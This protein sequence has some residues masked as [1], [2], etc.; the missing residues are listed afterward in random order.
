MIASLTY[1]ET[2]SIAEKLVVS[3]FVKKCYLQCK[4][5]VIEQKTAIVYESGQDFVSVYEDSQD[6]IAYFRDTTKTTFST[7]ET[8][9]CFPNEYTLSTTVRL[10]VF[11]STVREKQS[12]FV[13]ELLRSL[14]G[15]TILSIEVNQYNTLAEELGATEL[16]TDGFTMAVMID[17]L[18]KEIRKL[19][20]CGAAE[21]D[22]C[23]VVNSVVC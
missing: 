11:G 22:S 10:V 13:N 8:E 20:D 23:V 9:G 5:H 15:H 18:V 6:V 19:S 12:N 17:F 4:R 14:S 7:L 2:K 1:D 21:F 16:K 3:Q